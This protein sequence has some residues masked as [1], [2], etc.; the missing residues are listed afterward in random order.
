MR[1]LL[2]SLT[3]LCGFGSQAMSVECGNGI[4][5]PRFVIGPVGM[6]E[7]ILRICDNA[8]PGTVPGFEAKPTG[9]QEKGAL[10]C[11]REINHNLV[12][13]VIDQIIDDLGQPKRCGEVFEV[14]TTE[15]CP[16]REK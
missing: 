13:N 7:T 16:P 6:A 8:Q 1:Y 12:T 9:T 15:N 11:G 14:T 10:K 5:C 4:L 3:L 2:L